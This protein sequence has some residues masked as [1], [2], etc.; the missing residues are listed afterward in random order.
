M[1]TGIATICLIVCL[2]LGCGS[3]EKV[4]IVLKNNTDETIT[5]RAEAGPLKIPITLEPGKAWEGHIFVV[6]VKEIR[7]TIEKKK[8]D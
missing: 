7:V 4:N 6:K 8:K 3:A 1:K 5:I 2:L